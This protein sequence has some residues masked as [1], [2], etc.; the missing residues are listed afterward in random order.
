VAD[1]TDHDAAGVDS[2]RADHARLAMVIA[3][4]MWPAFLLLAG[5]LIRLVDPS[6]G[7][8]A[9]VWHGNYLGRLLKALIVALPIG[10]VAF[11]TTN[12]VFGRAFWY[13]QRR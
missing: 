2:G 12:L 11:G 5:A 4:L 7:L 6:F 9:W 13:R 3:V 10:V 8:G 1:V